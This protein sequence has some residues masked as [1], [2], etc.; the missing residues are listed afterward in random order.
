MSVVFIIEYNLKFK[1][2]CLPARSFLI[3]LL[4]LS[5][6]LPI[7]KTLSNEFASDTV[8]VLFGI[9]Q[10]IYILDS[11]KSSLLN[12]NNSKKSFKRHETIPLEE[13]MII[14]KASVNNTIFGNIAALIGV[15]LNFSRIEN[16]SEVIF[17][18]FLGFILYLFFPYYI[19]KKFFSKE[20]YWTF[21]YVF[22]FFFI[23]FF[24]DITIFQI[25]LIL[26][27]STLISI[28]FLMKYFEQTSL[29][30]V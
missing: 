18:Q 19:E 1:S 25:F 22:L 28:I 6:F 24:S 23:A 12:S 8:F 27:T 10:L 2:H 14:P 13:A 7:F 30:T 16:N 3:I 5:I 20:L 11:V 29:K 26:I 17:L 9:C 4:L 21:I 15:M